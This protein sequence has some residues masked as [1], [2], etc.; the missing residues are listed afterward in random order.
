VLDLRFQTC[1]LLFA[2]FKLEVD[3]LFLFAKICDNGTQFREFGVGII[4]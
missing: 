3:N 4:S 2:Q 1:I